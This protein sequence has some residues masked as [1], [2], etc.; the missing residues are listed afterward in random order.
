MGYCYWP[1][2]EYIKCHTD[3]VNSVAFSNDNLKIISGSDDCSIKIWDTVTLS[4]KQ[5]VMLENRDSLS[6]TGQLLN[7]LTGHTGT[8]R[9]VAFS[10]NIYS[11]LDKKLTDCINNYA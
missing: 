2:I 9:S 6:I 10:N 11:E 5:Q 4:A 7:T 3:D 1:V 8:I